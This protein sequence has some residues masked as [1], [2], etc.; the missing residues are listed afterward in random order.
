MLQVFAGVGNRHQ[1]QALGRSRW[2]CE[3][4][5]TGAEK[6]SKGVGCE[7]A[8]TDPDEGAY[9]RP[10]HVA[11]KGIATNVEIEVRGLAAPVG[12]GKVA[13]GVLALCGLAERGEVVGAEERAR[14]RIHGID[15]KLVRDLP[16]VARTER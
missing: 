9:Q 6:G 1:D 14:G 10:D 11:E 5:L 4:P 15:V 3:R 16:G 2:G 12:F 8:A 7:L 13:D